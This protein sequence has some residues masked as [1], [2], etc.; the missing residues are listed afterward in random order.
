MALPIFLM[1]FTLHFVHSFLC[2]GFGFF[3]FSS[4]FFL[5]S[6]PGLRAAAILTVPDWCDYQPASSD[7]WSLQWELQH[8]PLTAAKLSIALIESP[9]Q[10][11]GKPKLLLLFSQCALSLYALGTLKVYLSDLFAMLN[12][13]FKTCYMICNY[14][15]K[16]TPTKPKQKKRPPPNKQTKTPKALLI[17]VSWVVLM[18]F[19]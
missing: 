7:A 10:L 17:G 4:Q 14:P 15:L 11:H 19:Y 12:S 9:G 13:E 18:G 5:L 1:C 6:L 16:K 8:L 2:L 3:F